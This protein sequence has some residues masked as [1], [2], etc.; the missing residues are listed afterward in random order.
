MTA[1]SPLRLVFMGTAGFAVPSLEA[2]AAGRHRLVAVYTQPARPAGKAPRGRVRAQRTGRQ[3]WYPRNVVVGSTDHQRNSFRATDCVPPSV[4]MNVVASSRTDSRSSSP[5]AHSRVA[6]F[7]SYAI[8]RCSI[9][10]SRLP[11]SAS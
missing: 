4:T 2:L 8:L 6:G 5:A 7:F 3:L 1:A 11:W 10:T 9:A